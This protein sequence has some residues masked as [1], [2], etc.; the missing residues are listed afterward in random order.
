MVERY[1]ERIKRYSQKFI[2]QKEDIEDVVQ[3]I[4]LKSFEN[5]KSFDPKKKFSTW[6]YAIAHN[7]LVNFLK[8]KNKL[9]TSLIDF[10]T[11]LPH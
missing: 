1:E 9:P 8:K 2:S 6:L 3:N 7:E 4:F 10:D 5:I 11:F